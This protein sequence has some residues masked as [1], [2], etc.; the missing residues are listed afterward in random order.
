MKWIWILTTLYIEMLTEVLIM[1]FAEVK[2][3]R[4][5]SYVGDKIE[6]GDW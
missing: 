6:N 5:D 3:C 4:V 1:H 2:N